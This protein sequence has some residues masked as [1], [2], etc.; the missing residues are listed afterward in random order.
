[1][2][3]PAHDAGHRN[4][5]TTPFHART[6]TAV[7][8]AA[9]TLAVVLSFTLG[10]SVAPRDPNPTMS[11]S[12]GLVSLPPNLAVPCSILVDHGKALGPIACNWNAIGYV[13][14]GSA[15]SVFETKYH[16]VGTHNVDNPGGYMVWVTHPGRVGVTTSVQ[17]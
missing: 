14:N 3:Q 6:K 12:T 9:A 16:L 5:V 13:S 4:P 11:A 10:Y 15:R 1:M 17:P 2:T 7:R 8:A